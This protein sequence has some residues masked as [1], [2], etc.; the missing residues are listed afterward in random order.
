[1]SSPGGAATRLGAASRVE[2][3]PQALAID[4]AANLTVLKVLG[5]LAME[6][7]VPGLTERD[8]LASTELISGSFDS[9]ELPLL[10]P[11]E[12]RP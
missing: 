3:T 12:H 8:G 10:V 5:F 9:N 7:A 11:R 1:M 2:V 6:A 4:V